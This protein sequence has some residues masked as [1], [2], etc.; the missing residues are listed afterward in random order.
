MLYCNVS[1]QIQDLKYFYQYDVK[2]LIDAIGATYEI[3]VMLKWLVAN[4][5]E[6]VLTKS[7]FVSAQSLHQFRQI[8]SM[9]CQIIIISLVHLN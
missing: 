2:Q 3:V 4:T 6:R 5:Q 8:L 9:T 7:K 1:P